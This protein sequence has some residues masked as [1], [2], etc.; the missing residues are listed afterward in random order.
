MTMGERCWTKLL[1]V[2]LC[3]S[4]A[5]SQEEQPS[6]PASSDTMK[7]D[8]RPLSGVESITLGSLLGERS[9]LEPGFLVAQSGDTNAQLQFGGQPGLVTST[10]LGGRLSLEQMGKRNQFSAAYQ[11]GGIL[12]ENNSQSNATFHLAGFSDSLEF[13]RATLIVADRFSFLPG[14][15]AG[16]GGLAYGGAFSFGNLGNLPALNSSFVPARGILTAAAGYSNTALGQIEYRPGP[17]SS[18]TLAGAF[19]TLSSV[20][21]GFVSGNSA[22]AQTGYNR[23]LTAKDTIS[24]FYSASAFRFSGIAESFD[25]QFVAFGY[26]RRITGRLAFQVFGGPQVFS[27]TTPGH[28][29]TNTL[30]SGGA[31]L[32]YRWPRMEASLNLF[33]G[34]T[35]GAGVVAGAETS[36]ASLRWERRFSRAFSGGLW[37][38]YSYNFAAYTPSLARSRAFDYWE[39]SANLTRA[40][41]RYARLN[42]FYGFQTQ[43]SNLLFATSRQATGRS[44]LRSFFGVTFDFTYR[45]LGI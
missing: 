34:L 7:P 1:V 33:R 36:S 32:T 17:R 3:A 26:A 5:W 16:L 4:S 43:N 19:E 30:A 21:Q 40:L 22:I 6:P 9:Y 31:S 14:F 23:R 39:S 13:R 41:G 25:A 45:T 42:L 10:V 8:T 44:V 37:T 20:R 11:G 2:A 18:V 15:Y 28:S 38:G 24:V 12:Y 35:S 27:A 29:Q